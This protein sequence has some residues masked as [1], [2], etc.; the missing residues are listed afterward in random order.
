MSAVLLDTCAVIY[1]ANG[2][3]I[4]P[5]A[6]AAL[7]KAET[8]DGVLVSPVSAWEI[9]LLGR[10]LSRRGPQFLPDPKTWLRRFLDAPGVRVAELSPEIA[11]DSSFLP[12]GLNSDPADRLLVATAR[13]LNVPI[14]TR[15]AAILSFAAAGHLRAI[16][17]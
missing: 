11:I 13:A 4:D 2:E 10:A 12:E 16:G 14:M 5:Q 15:D 7:G 3:P 1:V 6:V 8:G 17:C 9:G